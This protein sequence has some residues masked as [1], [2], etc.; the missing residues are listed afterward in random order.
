M[1]EVK[2]K[3]VHYMFRGNTLERNRCIISEY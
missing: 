2:F 1:N 3:E